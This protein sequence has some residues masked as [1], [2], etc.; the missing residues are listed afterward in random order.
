[1]GLG[2]QR[3]SLG[4]TQFRLFR[5]GAFD[6]RQRTVEILPPGRYLVKFLITFFV[7]LALGDSFQGVF[8][9][10]SGAHLGNALMK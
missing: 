6:S 1:M 9:E 2:L 8:L 3:H 4:R 5:G 10:M 7:P